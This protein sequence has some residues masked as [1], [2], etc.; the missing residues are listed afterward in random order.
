MDGEAC[1]EAR[2]SGVNCF[3]LEN[4]FRLRSPLKLFVALREI[5]KLIIQ[6]KPDLLHLTMP[7]SHIVLS[8]ATLGLDIKKIWFQHGPV[9]GLLDRVANLFPVDM[10]W[11]NSNFL[12]LKHHQTWP[13]ARVKVGEAIIS[14]GVKIS[15]Q[16][17]QIF[18]HSII[19]L[20]GA[21]RI[22]SGKG[23]HNI[24]RALGEL[25]SENISLKAFQLF[26]AGSAKSGHDKEYNKELIALVESY[27]LTNEIKFL[28]HVENMEDFYHSLDIFIHSSIVPEPFG[29]VVAEAMANGCLVIGSDLGGVSDL[30][31]NGNT[32]ITFS[33]TSD[34]AVEELK[35]KLK[36]VLST[37]KD[38]A[39][40][41]YIKIADDGR[42]FIEKNYSVDRMMD[43]MENL[44]FKVSKK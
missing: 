34:S 40:N 38:K 32:G 24:V 37:E 23:F 28:D 13:K 35:K 5:R 31:Q 4:N 39:F 7:Y 44:Y 33:A 8:L 3:V 27:N 10:I 6:Y 17:H 12:K 21:G 14:L 29:L 26:I 25:V 30:L 18:S 43:Q 36:E 22:C 9:G 2:K 16:P 15:N 1:R 42:A 11:Y 20:G 41:E 19:S